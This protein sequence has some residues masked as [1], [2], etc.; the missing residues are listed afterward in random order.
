MVK[1]DQPSLRQALEDT[2]ADSREAPADE[3]FLKG[4]GRRRFSWPRSSPTP[5]K[6]TPPSGWTARVWVGCCRSAA[7]P[8]SR[9]RSRRAT[10]SVRPGSTPTHWP[11]P[12]DGI[13]AIENDLHWR[14]GVTLGED[15][16]KVRR[17][18]APQ[19]LPILRRLI[20]NLPKQDT[21]CHPKRSL[22]LS[23]N[24]G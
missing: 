5:G 2:F 13:W 8:T 15:V 6:S 14:L 10:T 9:D 11:L 22:H 21:T 23:R 16:C 18:N 3:Q 19:N 24:L 7:K 1:E 17:D 20:L 4:H 12:C